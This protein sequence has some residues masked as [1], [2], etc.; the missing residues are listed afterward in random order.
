MSPCSFLYNKELDYFF[1]K[2]LEACAIIAFGL[3]E[4]ISLMLSLSYVYFL[5]IL[6][7]KEGTYV[8]RKVH[9]KFI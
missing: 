7:I 1:L 5:D 8:L 4:R 9:D 3:I 6:L 2:C